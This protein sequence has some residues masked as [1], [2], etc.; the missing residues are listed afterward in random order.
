MINV[1]TTAGSSTTASTGQG[2][3]PLASWRYFVCL[4][5][6]VLAALSMNALAEYL[7]ATFRKE[8]VPLKQSLRI[9]IDRDKLK[10]EYR[11]HLYQPPPISEEVL[12]SLGTEEYMSAWLVDLGRRANNPAR[13][14]EL[15]VTYYTG[16]PDMVP[17]APD[18]CYPAAGW[19][20]LGSPETVAVEV[21]GV[22]APDDEIPVRVLRFRSPRSGASGAVAY[23]FYVNGHYVT[24]RFDVR[25][26]LANPF[27]RD[28]Y[29]AKI[30]LSFSD[31]PED[32]RRARRA[33]RADLLDALEPL[34]DKVVPI[35][36]EDYLPDDAVETGGGA[37]GASEATEKG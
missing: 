28:A 24:T 8:A 33:D 11:P 26:I 27:E 20:P 4:G 17:H 10:P 14:A 37:S 5:L 32:R 34:L 18:E 29:Y 19:D 30:E 9:P 35:L 31:D 7:G 15:F 25:R 23:F 16:K 3:A 6:L 22:G 21:G 13:V 12:D 2:R 1:Q 36:L